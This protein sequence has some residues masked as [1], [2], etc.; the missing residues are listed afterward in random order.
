M[1]RLI[2]MFIAA[3]NLSTLPT[4][5]NQCFKCSRVVFHIEALWTPVVA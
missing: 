1:D 5:N 2:F 3:E 4:S